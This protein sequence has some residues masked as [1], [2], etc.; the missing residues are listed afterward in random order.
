[1]LNAPEDDLSSYL[2]ILEDYAEKLND[3]QVIINRTT[4][5]VEL[6]DKSREVVANGIGVEKDEL[7]YV[8]F[9]ERLAEG[10]AIEEIETLPKIVGTSSKKG[11]EA[12][13]WLAGHF[14]GEKKFTNDETAMF[15]KLI[16]NTYRDAKFSIAN[17]FALLAEEIDKVDAHKAIEMANH[18]YP[19]NDIPTPGTVGGKCLSKDPHFL[20]KKTITSQPWGSDLFR[21]T[22]KTNAEFER[23]VFWKVM[24]QN[25]ES[26]GILG[27]GFKKDNGDE[28]ESPAI[29]IKDKLEEVDV[30]TICFD[31]HS[32]ER[33]TP[34]TEVLQETDVCLLAV[35]HTYFEEREEEIKETANSKII[36]IWGIFEKNEDTIRIGG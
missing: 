24:E 28:F 11:K 22:R 31:P 10:F 7:K 5:P 18:D 12:I 9:P 16:D 13:N 17:Q 1:T 30:N 19:R 32:D 14:E 25:P 3:D 20:M 23:K 29:R 6:V 26:V 4:L 34:M 35:N 36:D 15:I 33:D 2:D 8:T 21:H 27:T